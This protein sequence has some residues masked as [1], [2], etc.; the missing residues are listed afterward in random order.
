MIDL[1]SVGVSW[2]TVGPRNRDFRRMVS[3]LIG[4]PPLG[5]VLTEYWHTTPGPGAH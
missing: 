3:A 1:E 4:I 2:L 5:P